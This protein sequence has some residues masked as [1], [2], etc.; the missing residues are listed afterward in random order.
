VKLDRL[1]ESAERGGEMKST[2]RSAAL[3]AA[4][5]RAIQSYGE[6]R[7]CDVCHTR[8][9]R[10]NESGRCGAHRGWGD[11]PDR[12]SGLSGNRFESR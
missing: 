5:D 3:P 6:G 4:G 10:Y 7:T 11:G 12:P 9:S 1:K 2:T 8:L